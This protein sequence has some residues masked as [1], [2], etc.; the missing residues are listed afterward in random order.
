MMRKRFEWGELIGPSRDLNFPQ[1]CYSLTYSIYPLSVIYIV[2]YKS[3]NSLV[4][5]I[6]NVDSSTIIFELVE[7]KL[8]LLSI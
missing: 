6:D 4:I 2:L 8:S 7:V 1:P 3:P 5:F